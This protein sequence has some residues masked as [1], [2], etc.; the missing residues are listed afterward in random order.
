MKKI[1]LSTLLG[2]AGLFAQQI[3]SFEPTENLKGRFFG[4]AKM[5][6]VKEHATDGEHA[7]K[8]FYKGS[9]EDTWPDLNI[10][11]VPS[12]F[13][14]NSDNNAFF[15]DGWHDEKTAVALNYRID[16]NVGDSGWGSV[17]LYPKIKS[18]SEIL[19]D[20]MPMEDGKR[21]I[22][23]RLVIYRRMPRNDVTVWLDNFRIGK[24]KQDF[25]PIYYKAP[26]G[27]RQPTAEEMQRGFQLFQRNWMEHV[28]QNVKPQPT[29]ASEVVLKAIA[30]RGEAEPMTFSIYALKDFNAVTLD[31]AS[32]L[33]NAAGDVIPAEALQIMN[34]LC[35]NKRPSYP[36]K[37][38]YV[39]V[40]MVLDRSNK[41]KLSEN[42]TK[43]FWVDATVPKDAKPGLYTGAATLTMDGTRYELPISIQVR[44]FTVP[45]AGDRMF[46]E[47]LTPPKV[48]KAKQKETVEEEFAYMRALGMTSVG[49]CY[50]FDT[51]E[52]TYEDGKCGVKMNEDDLFVT[53]MNAYV[54][55]GYPQ[56]VV[57]LSDVG[58]GFAGR[59]KKGY[60]SPE[61]KACYQAFWSAMQQEAK[62]RGWPEIIVQPVDEPAWQDV[63][64]KER[65]KTLLAYLAE[66]PG[67]RSEQDGPGDDYFVNEAGPYA[68]VWNYN[69]RVGSPEQM[70]MLKKQGKLAVFYNCDVESYRTATSRYMGGFFQ[71]L[72]KADGCFNWALKSY[73][74]DVFDDLDS[75]NGDTTNFFPGN[76]KYA[77]GPGI[78]LVA[79]REGIDD[80]NYV[81]YLN[82]LIEKHP[83]PKADYARKVLDSVFQSLTYSVQLRD[84]AD[85]EKASNDEEGNS[86][87]TGVCNIKNGWK[88]ED[89]A[90][91]REI[92]ARQIEILLAGDKAVDKA[93]PVALKLEEHKSEATTVQE[94]VTPKKNA[95]SVLV[96]MLKIP[97]KIDGV[98]DDAC[99]ASAG[100][101]R[102]FTLHVG[103]GKPLAQTTARIL[104]DGECLYLGIECEEEYIDK[105]V[106]NTTANQGN[107]FGDDC[108]EIFIDPAHDNRGYKQIGINAL[109]SYTT[110]RGDRKEWKPE[111]KSA[112]TRGKDRWFVE[113][114]IPMGELQIKGTTFG[115]NVCRERRPIEIFELSCWSPTGGPFAQPARF[116]AANLGMA[117]FRA[118]SAD[119]VVLGKSSFYATIVNP[120]QD[121][122]KVTV[123][124]AWKLMQ[125][126][127]VLDNGMSRMEVAPEKREE[128]ICFNAV[129]KE[130]GDFEA[131]ISVRDKSGK[132]QEKQTVRRT[133]PQ[134]I[135][136]D[137]FTSFAGDKW[138]ARLSVHYSSPTYTPL[139]LQVAAV[140]N[141]QQVF[142]QPVKQDSQFELAVAK[143]SFATLD[144]VTVSLVEKKSGKV[145]YSVTKPVFAK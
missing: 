13:E 76:A 123:E 116:G 131:I 57:L 111:L 88:L 106:T 100:V 127:K 99:W 59:T 26:A 109:G 130:V 5:E 129:L 108:V 29:D 32:P 133:M 144:R 36:S 124:A 103:E 141:P 60:K 142:K 94:V 20:T 117:W 12:L 79:F 139:E 67:M 64:A 98:L 78:G 43:S 24:T 101:M 66:I 112:A 15:F 40:P 45:E 48:S 35:I 71:L 115:L 136:F 16:Y 87:V 85:F 53:A 46:G 122:E 44:S 8:V 93:E 41:I 58:Q 114:A 18:V 126:K 63:E 4:G 70:A 19:F 110:L 50:G 86:Q 81:S 69:G 107:V 27:W 51:K 92:I 3:V 140:S 72:S 132:I 90:C 17:K 2:C 96:P 61:Y 14:N 55:N 104:T 1:L 74:G 7:I 120:K 119:D 77:G 37:T 65:N 52:F 118:T 54:K 128:K 138:C 30:S 75:K 42:T 143:G 39:D 9:V 33:K 102:D 22:P 121:D 145:I 62:R 84:T 6:I 68:H 83:G 56:P 80:Y 137:D 38:Y 89:Y 105:I 25:K 97:P 135:T 113:I 47:Y 49:I 134:P 11:L 23:K 31:I 95:Y 34:I 28:F 82:S 91:A 73:G 21:R 10:I 125:G